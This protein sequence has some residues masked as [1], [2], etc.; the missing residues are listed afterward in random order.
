MKLVNQISEHKF[1]RLT[2][3]FAPGDAGKALFKMKLI[4]SDQTFKTIQKS[5][6][7]N[8]FNDQEPQ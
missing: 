1:P 6:Q 3:S 5:S 7:I 8:N 4:D 2:Q